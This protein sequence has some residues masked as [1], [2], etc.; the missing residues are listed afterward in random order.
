MYSTTTWRCISL[1]GVVLSLAAA[2]AGGQENKTVI[3]PGNIDLAVGAELLRAGD[4]QEGLERTLQG[5]AYATSARERVAGNSNACA[6]Y[7]MLEQPASAL[8]YCDRAI[9]IQEKHWRARTNRALAYLRLGRFEDCEA[10]LL[11]AEQQAPG[12][13]TVKLVRSMYRDAT[14]PVAPQVMI[15]DRRQD[16]DDDEE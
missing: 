10:D 15:D 2:V 7:V 16:A 8:P 11:I 1:V 13:R 9:E 4:A 5:L 12:A 14:D 3:G 6:G